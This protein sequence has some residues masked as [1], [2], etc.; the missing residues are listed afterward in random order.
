MPIAHD[1]GDLG[2]DGCVGPLSM[3]GTSPSEVCPPL[4]RY[5]YGVTCTGLIH[6]VTELSVMGTPKEVKQETLRGVGG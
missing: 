5:T 6:Q 4:C 1:L 3:L 2:S